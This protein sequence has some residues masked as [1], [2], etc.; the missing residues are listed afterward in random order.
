VI[1]AHLRDSPTP[2][3]GRGGIPRGLDA[4]LA[5]ALAK[6]PKDRF[7]TRSEFALAARRALGARVRPFGGAPTRTP[8]LLPI[9]AAAAFLLIL[10]AVGDGA[11]SGHK[12]KPP[13][14]PLRLLGKFATRIGS[15]TG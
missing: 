1:F 2:V 12:G 7:A 8:A 10:G 13:P 6:R 11:A 3:G 5:R 4:V 14:A 15:D 9:A